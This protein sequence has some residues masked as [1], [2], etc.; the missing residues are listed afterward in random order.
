MNQVNPMKSKL[1]LSLSL[2]VL[3]LVSCSN[4]MN[5]SES[6]FSSTSV[7]S[8]G[9]LLMECNQMQNTN[10]D[11]SAK[12]RV[13]RND[14]NIINENYIRLKFTKLPIGFNEGTTYIQFF[15]GKQNPNETESQFFNSFER[16]SFDVEANPN[17]ASTLIASGITTLDNSTNAIGYKK[18]T[19]VTIVLNGFDLVAGYQSLQVVLY[20]SST[21]QAYGSAIGL[22]PF[23]QVNPYTYQ[24]THWFQDSL[25]KLH[26]YWNL[27]N[28]G[29]S[30]ADLSAKALQEF[31][32]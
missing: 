26:P 21:H 6:S 15:R 23:I 4:S 8:A 12:L 32:F 18:L 2:L 7:D 10:L 22:V 30:D 16:V 19:D 25:V 29:L 9:N 31:C 11:L 27:R 24:K 17:Q 5:T 3:F 14:A 20:N 28:S 13:F 1:I